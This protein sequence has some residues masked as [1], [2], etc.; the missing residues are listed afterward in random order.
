[1]RVAL[2]IL[3]LI[4]AI[5]VS[6]AQISLSLLHFND[7]HG[8]FEPVSIQTGVCQPGENEQGIC[9]GGIA[10]LYT[11]IQERRNTLPNPIVLNAGDNYQGSLMYSLF[12]W[13]ITLQFMKQF[14]F[15]ASA[16]GNHEFDDRIAG[17]VPYVEGLGSPHVAANMDASQEPTLDGKFTASITITRQGT[18]I[19]IVGCITKFTPSQSSPENVQFLDEIPAV[20]A[21][22]ERLKAQGV[23]IIILLSHSGY[24]YDLE[25]ARQIPDLDII[26]GSHS[27]TFL[28]TGTPPSNDLPVADYPTVISQTNGHNCLIVQAY[29]FSKYLGV[30]EV[31]FDANGEVTTW[32]GNP[33]LLDNTVIEDPGIV[34]MLAPWKEEADKTGLQTI[35]TSAVYLDKANCYNGECNLG[36]FLADGMVHEY[37]ELNDDDGWTFAAIAIM[38]PGGLRAPMGESPN[39]TVNDLYTCQPFQNTIDTI[40]LQGK[41]I[42]ELMELAASPPAYY[43]RHVPR[44]AEGRGCFQVS[45]MH[46]V[47]DLNQ[48]A[49]S[50]LKSLSLRCAR[51]KIPEYFPVNSEEW[52]TV[53]MPS[54]LSG[55]S[56]FPLIS[57]R[58]RNK[59]VGRVDLDV[60]ANFIAK[61][62]PIVTAV[63]GRVT[64]V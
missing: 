8:R 62:S 31:N 47:Y 54:F 21:E 22:V 52:Y 59:T 34:S 24:T 18:P 29:A 51:C 33:V 28:Y 11:A 45:G 2:A 37:T 36:S 9:Y 43:R 48:P 19:G 14:N 20:T 3:V 17:L 60:F 44:F 7:F 1:M 25:M 40:E 6:K 26:V 4:G 13:N 12:R 56:S 39:I 61:S 46:A 27:H 32:T 49:G 5:S 41:D 58:G 16:F 23:K 55:G 63:E 30:L 35:G 10:R 57:E 15:D 38:N 42:V 64:V 53:A 50:R